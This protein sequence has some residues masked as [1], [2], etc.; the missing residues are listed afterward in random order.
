LKRLALVTALL[1]QRA[2][3]FSGQRQFQ[4]GNIRLRGI[5]GL[6]SLCQIGLRL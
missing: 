3:F 6:L 1:P 4:P 2:Q 5:R